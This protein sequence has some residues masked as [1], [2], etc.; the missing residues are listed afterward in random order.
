MMPHF[1]TVLLEDS[2]FI[3]FDPDCELRAPVRELGEPEQVL[4]AGK[5][6][7]SSLVAWNSLRSL[8]CP[9][10]SSFNGEI[11]SSME[12]SSETTGVL[13]ELQGE[14]SS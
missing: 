8:C 5:P 1:V 13:S 6:S 2:G 3:A 4:T 12:G 7:D 14:G 10:S 9:I 11:G